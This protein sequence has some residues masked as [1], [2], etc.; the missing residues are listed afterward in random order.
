VKFLDED[1]TRILDADPKLQFQKLVVELLARIPTSHKLWVI[2]LDALDEC[3]QDRGQIFLR[4]L[5]DNIRKIPVHVRFFL[6]GRPDVPSYLKHGT[7]CSLMH[8]IIL[9]NIDKGIV[10]QDIRTYVERSLDGNSWTPPSHWTPQ[11]QHVDMITSRAD[12]LFVFAATAVRYIHAGLPRVNPQKSL[13]YL[14]KG[15]ALVDLDE[16]YFHI[17]NEAIPVPADMDDRDQESYEL[18]IQKLVTNR[19]RWLSKSGKLWSARFRQ[20]NLP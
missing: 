5:S 16:L 20:G 13:E 11:V 10:G 4:W 8:G 6:T 7:L 17:V 3:G 2:C 15:T 1:H 19:L 14:L 18:S 12:G 9:D